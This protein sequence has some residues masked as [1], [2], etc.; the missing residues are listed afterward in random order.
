MWGFG[1]GAPFGDSPLEIL[2][3]RIP[4]ILKFPRR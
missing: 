1:A 3:S 4:E 2:N